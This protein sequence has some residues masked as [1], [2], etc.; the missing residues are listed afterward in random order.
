[1]PCLPAGVSHR[2]SCARIG[3]IKRET[4]I[5]HRRIGFGR[6][7][8]LVAAETREQ[9]PF[10]IECGH[11]REGTQTEVTPLKFAFADIVPFDEGKV[12]F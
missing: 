1:M 9:R 10:G 12:S 3:I 6:R 2:L 4:D 8:H 7:E 5:G 11:A